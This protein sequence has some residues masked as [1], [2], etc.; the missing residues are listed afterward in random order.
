MAL[1]PTPSSRRTTLPLGWGVGPR[2]LL[3]GTVLGLLV[4]FWLIIRLNPGS[5]P[6]LLPSEA[7]AVT[8]YGIAIATITSATLAILVLLFNEKASWSLL[9]RPLYP[10]SDRGSNWE[11]RDERPRVPMPKFGNGNGHEALMTGFD[12]SSPEPE[13][14]DRRT[15]KPNFLAPPDTASSPEDSLFH[16]AESKGKGNGNGRG[17]QSLPDWLESTHVLVGSSRDPQP[18]EARFAFDRQGGTKVQNWGAD[19]LS[20]PDVEVKRGRRTAVEAFRFSGDYLPHWGLLHCPFENTPDPRYYFPSSHHQE[21]LHR[22]LYGIQ[23]RKGAV[24]LTGE[25]GCGKTL[26]SRALLQQ[27]PADTYDTA[28]IAAPAF[29]ATHLLREI[30]YQLGVDSAGTGGD[31]LHRLNDRLLDNYKRGLDTV[32]IIDE[33]QAIRDERMF[34]E[35]RLMLNFQLNDRFL[36]TLV[37]LGQPELK[38]RVESITQLSQRIAIRHHL[39]PF[40]AQETAEYVRYRINR[41]GGHKETFTDEACFLIHSESGGIPRRINSLCDLCLLIG[42]MDHVR[43]IDR[44]IVLRAGAEITLGRRR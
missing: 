18:M 27:L 37:L 23:A 21:A 34:E 15:P 39:S 44:P 26:M 22:L 13:M 24:M 19:L 40:T 36:L 4:G 32:L 3:Q 35:I 38:A 2:S 25:I 33:A 14:A 31:L 5:W 7:Y 42:F 28:L 41:A 11:S 29:E 30:L 16:P 6:Q 20:L 9:Y 8:I 1:S 43:V 10:V 17:H 12:D